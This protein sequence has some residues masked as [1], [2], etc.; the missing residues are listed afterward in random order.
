METCNSFATAYSD[1]ANTACA[2]DSEFLKC[3]AKLASRRSRKSVLGD[4][5]SIALLSL[6]AFDTNMFLLNLQ[7]GTCNLQNFALQPHNPDDY[8]TEMVLARFDHKAKCERWERF[9]DEI[10]CGDKSTA[11]FLQKSLVFALTCD[12][13]DHFHILFGASTR[14]GKSTLTEAVGF[15]F[16]DYA[17]A[18]QPQTLAKC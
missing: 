17:W 14:Y 12:I 9:I 3:T 16:D 10:M 7:N 18:V 5:C 13:N 8:I 1:Y 15:I 11:A 4:A 6:A 2:D